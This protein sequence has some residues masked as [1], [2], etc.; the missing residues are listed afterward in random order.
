MSQTHNPIR[1]LPRPAQIHKH[2]GNLLRELRIARRLLRLAME[3][4]LQ[5]KGSAAVTP[6][7]RE[8]AR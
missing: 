3:V 7:R 1:S 6:E 4:D 2:I 8:V 5:A